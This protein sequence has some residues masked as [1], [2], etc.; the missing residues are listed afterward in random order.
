M[1]LLDNAH[2]GDFTLWMRVEAQWRR[3]Q[4]VAKSGT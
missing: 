2:T 4:A 1:F 3:E